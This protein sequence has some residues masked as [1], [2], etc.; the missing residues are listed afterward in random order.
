M[1]KELDESCLFDLVYGHL[2]VLVEQVRPDGHVQRVEG[3]LQ[4][5]VGVQLVD[6]VEELVD[7][8][9]LGIRHHD[10]LD[11][12]EGLAAVQLERVSLELLNLQVEN[13]GVDLNDSAMRNVSIQL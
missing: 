4:G 3:V 9:L 13:F 7:A 12:R 2:E 5:I 11:A 6:L 1:A 10:K 8:D